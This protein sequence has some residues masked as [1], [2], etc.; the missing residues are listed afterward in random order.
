MPSIQQVLISCAVAAIV[1]F[2]GGCG[3]STHDAPSAPDAPPTHLVGQVVLGSGTSSIPALRVLA[4]ASDA[5]VHNVSGP[6]DATGAFDFWAPIESWRATSVDLIVDA[7]PGLHRSFHPTMA[8]ATPVNAIAAVARPL[9]VPESVTFTST[10]FGTRTLPFSARAAF[11]I[12]CTDTT[13]ANCNSFFPASWLASTPQLWPEAQLPIPVAF[14]RAASAGTITDADSAAVWTTIGQM[15]DALGRQLFRP[16]TLE[17]LV[18]PNDAGYV[19]GAVLISIDN[20]LS[21]NAGYTNWRYDGGGSLFEAKTRVGSESALSLRGLMTHELLHAL[22]FHHTCMW[23]SV[24]GG[25][26]C[27]LLGGATIQDASAFNLAW[28][29]RQTIIAHQPT[30]LLADALRG[31]QQLETSIVA[32]IAPLSPG[33]L[34][35]YA[36]GERRVV[37]VRGRVVVTDGAP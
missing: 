31:E 17:S 27:P 14:N 8:Q 1:V 36:P 13:N 5:P 4:R 23:P 30:T 33:A 16:A 15:H 18:A 2:A 26:G 29:L 6:I 3:S 35:P 11:T 25:Y 24:M 34:M 20:T 32:S 21:P 12:V 22:G 7:P 28:T 9:V 19:V 37:V 10:T